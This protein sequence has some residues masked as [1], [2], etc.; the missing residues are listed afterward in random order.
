M[1]R[2]HSLVCSF[3]L[4][5]AATDNRA[6]HVNAGNSPNPPGLNII[7]LMLVAISATFSKTS[8]EFVCHDGCI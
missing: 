7:V 2:K 6:K 4:L 8:V 5:P 3:G 1:L